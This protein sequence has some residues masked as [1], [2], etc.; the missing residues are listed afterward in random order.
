MPENMQAWCSSPKGKPWISHNTQLQHNIITVVLSF[1]VTTG[2]QTLNSR[3]MELCQHAGGFQCLQ[4]WVI[5]VSYG[6][7][8]LWH[9]KIFSVV[10][11]PLFL[12]KLLHPIISD[13][14]KGMHSM[15]TGKKGFSQNWREWSDFPRL[16]IFINS[17]SLPYIH[18]NVHLNIKSSTCVTDEKKCCQDTAGEKL[19]GFVMGV[20]INTSIFPD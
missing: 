16:L 15:L 13:G 11:F 14:V 4:I 10:W 5:L 9:Y 8:N 1:P 6:R 2:T 12:S 20:Y 3:T 18:T 17:Y 7:L 19:L